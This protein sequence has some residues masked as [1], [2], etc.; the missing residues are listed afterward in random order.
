MGSRG[1][2]DA[3]CRAGREVGLAQVAEQATPTDPISADV[4]DASQRQ[5][6]ELLFFAYRDFTGDADAILVRYGFGRAHH[7]VI[8][9]V[10]RRLGSR[11]AIYWLF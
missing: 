6:I 5:S 1:S 3:V 7:R 4:S 10:G 11:W 8:Y 9:F 2:I